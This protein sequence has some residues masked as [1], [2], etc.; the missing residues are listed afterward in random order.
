MYKVAGKVFLI[1]TEDPAERIV[2]VKVDPD[3]GARCSAPT[4]ASAP[5]DTSTNDTGFRL[6]RGR[7]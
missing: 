2:T 5:D 1:V 3:H 6:P 7:A 4:K